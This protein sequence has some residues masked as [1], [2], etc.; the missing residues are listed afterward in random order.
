M[1]LERSK[2]TS[3]ITLVCIL[4]AASL[5]AG[6]ATLQAESSPN[7]PTSG[8]DKLRRTLGAIAS[9][10]PGNSQVGIHVLDVT[11]GAEIYKLNSDQVFNPASNAKIVTAACALKQLGPEFRFVTSLHG[12]RD[13][14]VIRGPLYLKGHADPTLSMDDLWE[15]IRSLVASGVRRIEGGVVVDDSYFDKENLPYAFDQQKDEDAVFRS[16]VGAVSLNNNALSITIRPGLQG[17]TPARVFVDPPGYAVIINDT[18]TVAEGSHNPK[19]SAVPFENR[20]RVR[21]W[22]QIPLG[23]RPVTYFRRID[24]PSLFSGYGL[25]GA[26]SG[27]GISVG[28]GIQTGP[29]KPGTPKLAEHVSLPLSSLLLKTGKMSNNFVTEMVLKTMGAEADKGPGTWKRAIQTVQETLVAWGLPPDTYVYR[30]G[31]GL[32]DANRF[33]PSH[34]TTVLRQ[35]YLDSEIRPEFLSQL[36]TGGVDGTIKS[37]YQNAAARGHVRAKTGT[38]AEVSALSGYVLNATGN[39]AIAFSILI[40]KAPGYISAGR[41][42]QERLVNAIAKFLNP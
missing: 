28:G 10:S 24:N 27:V 20:T 19:I 33:S 26:L 38:L 35:A 42:F 6:S 16:P 25:K 5:V 11:S 18:V 8:F 1:P 13:G 17:T 31:S 21:V 36:A 30:N 29:L 14:G 3:R 39:R 40:N 2:M 22:G 23:A 37:R 12:R 9:K 41:A 7:S 4:L 15:M 32:F 34:L